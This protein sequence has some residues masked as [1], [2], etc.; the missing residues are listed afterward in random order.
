MMQSHKNYFSPEYH[1]FL[2][3]S[4]T[5]IFAITDL[6][7]GTGRA[8]RFQRPQQVMLSKA[9]SEQATIHRSI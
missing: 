3:R 2:P 4:T 1:I 8:E 6:N 5:T 9:V 7:T